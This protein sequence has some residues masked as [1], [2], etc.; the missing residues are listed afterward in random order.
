MSLLKAG[1]SVNIRVGSQDASE[2]NK[3]PAEI[4][5][6]QGLPHVAKMIKE[7]SQN[8][9]KGKEGSCPLPLLVY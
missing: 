2:K 1:A 4:A 9:G 8:V 7:F 3:T 6:N 5:L